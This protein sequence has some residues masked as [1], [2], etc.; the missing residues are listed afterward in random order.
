MAN[1]GHKNVIGKGFDKKPEHINRKGRPPK[2]VSFILKE[3]KDKGYEPAKKGQVLEAYEFIIA[4][5][6]DEIVKISKDYTLP[7]FMSIVAK[8]I[9]SK[10]GHDML[11]KMLDRTHGKPTNTTNIQSDEEKPLMIEIV[12]RRSKD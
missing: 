3:L 12:D 2:L 7:H 4:L 10:Y 5:P 9:L 11:E 1:K 8:R 6:R